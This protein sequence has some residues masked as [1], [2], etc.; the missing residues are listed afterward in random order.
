MRRI[1]CCRACGS[2]DLTVTLDL[3]LQPIANALEAPED[4]G[5]TTPLTPL[6]MAVC[7]SCGM[8]QVMETPAP[9]ALF[10]EDYPYFSS[11]IPSLVAHAKA[12]AE[13]LVRDRHLG[14]ESMVIEVASNDGY[15]LRHVQH[16]GVP[17]L[18][19]DPAAGPVAAARQAGVPTRQAFFGAALA[20]SLVAE[21]LSADVI[22]ANNVLAH[23]EDIDGFVAGI[24][25]LLKPD[26]CAVFEFPT[27]VDLVEKNAFDTIYHEHVFYHSLV[28]LE[29]LFA[30]H[31]LA[32]NDLAALPI[33]GGSVRLTVSRT[34]G[35]SA[36]LTAWLARERRLGIAR[37]ETHVAFAARV[38]TMRR[39][40]VSLL[41]GLKDSGARIAA[42]GAAAKGVTLLT[43]AGLDR[44]TIDFVVDRNTHKQGRLMPG[45]KLPIR[46]VEAL[47]TERPDYV[48]LLAWNFGREIMAQNDAYVRQGG[49]FIVPAPEPMIVDPESQAVAGENAMSTGFWSPAREAA[50]AR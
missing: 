21:G 8:A 2:A 3:G 49:R 43:Y 20:R 27:L 18:G 39:R 15:L 26:G 4:L 28:A 45:L 23:V 13:A 46:P 5:K 11:F 37:V 48:L 31:G 19:I 29:P 22:L 35:A 10:G 50:N 42:Y 16:L 36:A 30:R 12:H 34:G 41:A 32:M 44:G 33:H 1:S 9:E 47:M 7:G 38:A 6:E 25:A 17:V 24:A 14:P 40:L